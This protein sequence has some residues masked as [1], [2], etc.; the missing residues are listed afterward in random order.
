MAF[1]QRLQKIEDCFYILANLAGEII[2]MRHI[3]RILSNI[4]QIMDN[5]WQKSLHVA[6]KNVVTIWS[7]RLSKFANS[8]FCSGAK[9]IVRKSCRS[10]NIVRHEYIPIYLQKSASIQPRTSP[11]DL[12]TWV[13]PSTFYLAWIPFLQPT[14]FVQG[15]AFCDQ[16]ST[17][18]CFAVALP[19]SFENASFWRHR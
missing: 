8:Y 12:G 16:S 15:I 5:V 6:E 4:W 13:L 14:Q 2:W 7:N 17:L 10:L 19:R 18:Q 3:S 9:T 11:L 1:L